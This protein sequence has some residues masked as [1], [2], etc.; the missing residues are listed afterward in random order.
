MLKIKKWLELSRTLDSD[1]RGAAPANK[2][3]F[4]SALNAFHEKLWE[5]S[6]EWPH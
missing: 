2:F 5:A 3:T 1:P 4:Y 6:K